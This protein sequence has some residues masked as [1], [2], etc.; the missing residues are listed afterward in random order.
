GPD[1][2]AMVLRV[3]YEL[4][5]SIEPHGL[6][7]QDRGA[8]DI[9]IEGL[10]PAGGIDQQG[11]G[12]GMAF[13]KAIV[14]KAFYLAEAAFGELFRISVLHHAP[15]EI[16]PVALERAVA[17]EGCHG[18]PQLVGLS[19]RETRCIYGNLHRLFL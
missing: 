18:P 11:K 4:G 2:D 3:A 8:E 13:G 5:G 17:P 10:E 19:G 14:A 12:G 6:R 16:L 9:R 15:D 1:L 7:I